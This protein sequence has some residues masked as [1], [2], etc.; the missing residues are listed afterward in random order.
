MLQVCDHFKPQWLK[1]VATANVF[2]I[3]QFGG[4][5]RVSC[6]H[7]SAGDAQLARRDLLPSRRPHSWKAGVGWGLVVPLPQPVGISPAARAFSCYGVFFRLRSEAAFPLTWCSLR[8]LLSLHR[9]AA[10]YWLAASH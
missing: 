5:Q 7:G 9:A 10:I 6:A 1:T 2:L 3:L 4:A 8:I